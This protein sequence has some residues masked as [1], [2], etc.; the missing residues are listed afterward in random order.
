MRVPVMYHDTV[1]VYVYAESEKSVSYFVIVLTIP[2]RNP[3]PR[4]VHVTLPRANHNEKGKAERA[5][6]NQFESNRYAEAAP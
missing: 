5:Q 4:L 2:Q 6:R 1:T 3:T